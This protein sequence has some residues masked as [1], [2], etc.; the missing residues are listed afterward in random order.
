MGYTLCELGICLYKYIY[1]YDFAGRQ[2]G[3]SLV[4]AWS[5]KQFE[6]TGACE[7]K[8]V[9]LNAEACSPK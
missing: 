1:I 5:D 4:K 9:E 8:D 2:A 3:F 6:Q 7:M